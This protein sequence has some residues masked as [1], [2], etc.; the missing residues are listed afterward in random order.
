MKG[1]WVA[2]VTGFLVFSIRATEISTELRLLLFPPAYF[3]FPVDN[4]ENAL[5]SNK[6]INLDREHSYVN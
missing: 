4:R 6:G 5:I 3:T 1:P 2:S